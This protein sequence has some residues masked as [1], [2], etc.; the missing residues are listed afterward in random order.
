MHHSHHSLSQSKNPKGLTPEEVTW[1]SPDSSFYS[2]SQLPFR[3]SFGPYRHQCT[4]NFPPE[5][6]QYTDKSRLFTSDKAP[7]FHCQKLQ[8]TILCQLD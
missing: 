1:D 6:P 5:T 4:F 2:P 7:Q 8:A 3:K